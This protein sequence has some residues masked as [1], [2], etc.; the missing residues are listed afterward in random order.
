[1]TASTMNRRVQRVADSLRELLATLLLRE[2]KDPRIGM[3][4]LTAVHLTADL[5]HARVFF[6]ILGPADKRQETLR[7]LQSAS[8]FLRSE[9]ARRLKLRVVPDL[10]FEFDPS[11]EEADRVL[12]LLRE[13]MPKDEES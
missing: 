3:V 5:R 9:I 11:L 6:S 10:V 2:V 1:M 8:G 12:R 13:S 7:G 4:T